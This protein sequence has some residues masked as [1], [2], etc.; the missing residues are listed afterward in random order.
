MLWW[1][2]GVHIERMKKKKEEEEDTLSPPCRAVL[3][4]REKRENKSWVDNSVCV[5]VKKTENQGKIFIGTSI[6]RPNLYE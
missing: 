1:E 3:L 5:Y 2:E 6:M 4:F